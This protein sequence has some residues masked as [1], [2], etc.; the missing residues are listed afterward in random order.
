MIHPL[1]EKND[2]DQNLETPV[3]FNQ[4]QKFTVKK[5]DN[6]EINVKKID[7]K[8]SSKLKILKKKSLQFEVLCR[9]SSRSG[10]KMFNPTPHLC[11]FIHGLFSFLPY[12]H[13]V[14]KGR[15][16]TFLCRVQLFQLPWIRALSS[17]SN[18]RA[19][20]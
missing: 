2:L 12:I 3:V 9:N 17:S 10:D 15:V 8:E 5:I 16:N 11:L 4:L 20:K 13:F 1:P 18:T 19:I 6:K 14:Q 7:N